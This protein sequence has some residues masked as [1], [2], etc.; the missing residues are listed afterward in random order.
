MPVKFL[1]SPRRAFRYSPFGSRASATLQRG[2]DEYFEEFAGVHQVARHPPLGAERR[3]E[4]DEHDQG[5]RRS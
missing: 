5:R 2:I 4:G 1:S 3:D